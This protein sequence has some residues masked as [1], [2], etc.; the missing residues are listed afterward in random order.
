MPKTLK[1]F[2]SPVR[3]GK[4]TIIYIHN[5]RIDMSDFGHREAP[6]VSHVRFDPDNQEWHAFLLDGREIARDKS[7]QVVVD[8]EAE[9]INQMFARGEKIPGG[10]MVGPDGAVI[11]VPNPEE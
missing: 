10:Y 9:V 2:V 1:Y 6:K 4:V 7:R 8:T 3:D 11:Q 5:D